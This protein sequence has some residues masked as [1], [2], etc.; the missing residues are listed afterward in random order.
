MQNVNNVIGLLNEKAPTNHFLAYI[1]PKEANVLKSM[2]GSGMPGPL[3]MMILLVL[4]F[5]E[6]QHLT[7]KYQAL[8]E[9][10]MVVVMV[11][12]LILLTQQALSLM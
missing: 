2:G 12:T 5:Q 9:E 11:M 1:N 10:M 3:N 7:I 4:V 8:V 6:Q